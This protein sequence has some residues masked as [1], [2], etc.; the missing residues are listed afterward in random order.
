MTTR[1]VQL[2]D[3]GGTY[4]GSFVPMLHAV[5]RAVRSRGW[6]VHLAF[7]EDA[8]GRPWAPQLE[9]DGIPLHFLP[10]T[11]VRELAAR[12]AALGEGADR[13]LFHTHFTT[14]DV[15]AVIAARRFDEARVV[16]HLH[17]HVRTEPR[18]KLRNVLKYLAL[19]GHVDAILGV[20]PDVAE[21]ARRRGAPNVRYFPN[22]IDTGSMPPVRPDERAAARARLGITGEV[23]LL[24]YGWDWHRKAGDL[25]VDTVALLR[26]RGHDVVGIS[27]GATKEAGDGRV[28]VVPPTGELRGLLAAADVFVS[29]SRAEGMPYSVAE[30]LAAGI[31]VAATAIPGQVALCE[32][33]SGC[34]LAGLDAGAIANAVEQLLARDEAAV[35][36]DTMTARQRM[37]ERH[38]LEPWSHDLVE[39][40]ERLLSGSSS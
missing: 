40:Y 37:V 15:P 26:D 38:D 7:T 14:F 24:H 21:T 28:R 10:R 29:C 16:W 25:F 6:E 27:V 22:A 35:R 17:S 4:P 1:V 39:L 36:A 19:R 9:A 33:L 31:A 34:R 12:V 18:V 13:V 32:G 23:V 5:S 3:Y 20:A 11:G 8:R 30:A 2:A